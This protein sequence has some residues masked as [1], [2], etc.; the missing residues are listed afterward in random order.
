[1]AK[2]TKSKKSSAEVSV[3]PDGK[4]EEKWR[5]ESD[6]RTLTEAMEIKADKPR[7][8]RALACARDK[9]ADMQKVVDVGV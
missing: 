8:K 6:M 3:Y 9:L 2:K 5:A 7:H 1:M 4:T